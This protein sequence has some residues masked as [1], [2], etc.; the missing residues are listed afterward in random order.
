MPASIFD[1]AI[2]ADLLGDTELGQIFSETAELGAML[3]VE[4]ALARAQGALGIIPEA[5][6]GFLHGACR[7]LALDPADLAAATGHDAVPVPALV[8]A[9]RAALAVPEHAAWLHFGATSQDIV[10][11]ALILRLRQVAAILDARLAALTAALGGLA[12]AHA[13]L[14]MLART[15]GQAAVPTTFGATVATWGMPLLRH[16]ERL[17]QLLPRLLVVSLSGAAGTLAAMGGKGPD[18]RAAL[19]AGLDLGDPG[20]SWHAARDRVAEFAG[21]CGGVTASI[22]KMAEDIL[23]LAR[24]PGAEVTLAAAGISST[25]PQKQNPVAPSVAAAL[26]RFAHALTG[27]VEASAVHREARDGAAWIGEWLALPQLCLATGR[28]LS[29]AR[30]TACALAPD[31]AAL[32]R[33]LEEGARLWSA[34]ALVFALA[35]RRPRP[36]AEAIAKALVAEAVATGAPLAALAA[37]SLP[38]VDWNARLVPEALLGEAPALARRFA[39]AAAAG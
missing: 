12:E 33:P 32:R 37:R 23:L 6:A 3:E 10:D 28:A 36:E 22:G 18:V 14:P 5:A 38:D 34:E 8:A 11:T 29:I 21:W 24:S 4:G 30:A 27:A 2:Y 16:R 39:T 31:A 13:D 1:S 25:M 26:C 19:A 9:V 35:K 15:Y 17:R 7:D 20:E